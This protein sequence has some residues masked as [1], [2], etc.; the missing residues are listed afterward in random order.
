MEIA[1]VFLSIQI[2]IY[3]LLMGDLHL[4]VA[5]ICYLI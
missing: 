3:V 4:I 2:V 1:A 5:D